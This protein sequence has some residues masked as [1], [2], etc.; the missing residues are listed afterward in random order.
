MFRNYYMEEF[1]PD[2]SFPKAERREFGFASFEGQMIRHKS[3]QNFEE[4]K[5][6]MQNFV[7]RDAYYSCAYYENPTAEMERKGW[8]G[9]D[10]I[11]DIDT[12][13]IPTPCNKIHD[14]WVCRN[15]GFSGKGITPNNCP[16]CNGEKFETSTWLCQECLETAK[17]EAIKLLDILINDFGFSDKDIHVYF[18]GHRGYHVHIENEI[19]QSLDPISRKEIADYICGIGFNEGMGSS[20]GWHVRIRKGLQR[21][22]LKAVEEDFTKLNLKR[23]IVKALLNNRKK[24]LMNLEHGEIWKSVKGIG[25]ETWGKIFNYCAQEEFVKIDTVVTADVHRLV[26][27]PNTL[28]GKTGF[29]KVKFPISRINDFDPFKEAI[30]L[31]KGVVK[32]LV[33]NSPQFR[34]G[35]E[36]FG[37]YKNVRVELPTAAAL[38]LVCKGRAEVY[39]ENV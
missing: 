12:D 18:S 4:V 8:L 31:R 32:T 37:P 39:D 3:F 21:F 19:V 7:P 2:A 26:R 20:T 10:L 38:L 29:K 25:L 30:A 28:H 24:I 17:N 14:E 34:I 23:N 11:F 6:F 35:E 9:A 5:F 13:H 36:I 16:V 33:Y 15:C 22:L 27:L 1:P